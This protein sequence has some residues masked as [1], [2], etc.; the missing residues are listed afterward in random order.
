MSFTFSALQ[1]P[2]GIVA[3]IIHEIDCYINNGIVLW[4]YGELE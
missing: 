3:A 2:V 4:C 1:L